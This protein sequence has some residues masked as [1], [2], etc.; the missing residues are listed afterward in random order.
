MWSF[1]SSP[2]RACLCPTKR[3]CG[4]WHGPANYER[5][6]NAPPK[7]AARL[8]SLTLL[9]QVGEVAYLTTRA[10]EPFAL[11]AEQIAACPLFDVLGGRKAKQGAP[12]GDSGVGL[13]EGVVGRNVFEVVSKRDG[14][15]NDAPQDVVDQ[16]KNSSTDT[17]NSADEVLQTVRGNR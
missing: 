16:I 12:S 10:D 13:A 8:Q 14:R 9:L 2:G 6:K 11:P 15:N 5:A 17:F 4:P 7:R 3:P 1:C